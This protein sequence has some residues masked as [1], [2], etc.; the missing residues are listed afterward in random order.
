MLRNYGVMKWYLKCLSRSF[1]FK[2][3]SRR[4]EYW[5]FVLFNFVFSLV[6]ALFDVFFDLNVQGYCIGVLSGVYSVLMLIPGLAVVVRRFH[7]IGK[8]GWW[9]LAGFIPFVG[10][11][12]LLIWFC[13]PGEISDNQYGPDPIDEPDFTTAEALCDIKELPK[14]KSAKIFG[15]VLLELIVL[16]AGVYFLE[17]Y[18]FNLYFNNS[19]S[20]YT[21]RDYAPYS[22]VDSTAIDEYGDLVYWY[23]LRHVSELSGEKTILESRDIIEILDGNKDGYAI[24]KTSDDE[25]G[26]YGPEGKLVLDGSKISS[27]NQL[28]SLRLVKDDD[29]KPLI[30]DGETYILYDLEGKQ[31]S[32]TKSFVA[33]HLYEVGFAIIGLVMLVLAIL[34]YFLI[35]R[36]N[37][38]VNSAEE[39]MDVDEVEPTDLSEPKQQ[40]VE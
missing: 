23:Q 18:K 25:W 1:D 20:D 8:S 33:Q 32:T 28:W 14:K 6:L 7:D 30:E 15:L 40:S 13:T 12:L 31:I 2:G 4:K 37:N 11:I 29:G 16:V 26:V 39:S 10:S 21:E 17:D 3:R 22:V 9:L 35:W 19:H 34:W 24:I 38:H 27:I 5:M 36:R